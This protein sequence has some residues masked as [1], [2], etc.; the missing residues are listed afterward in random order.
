MVANR[1]LAE[2]E[3]Q[4]RVTTV[5]GQLGAMAV[6]RQPTNDPGRDSAGKREKRRDP[7][8]GFTWE[9]CWKCE[10]ARA[11]KELAPGLHAI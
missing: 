7:P 1:Y 4:K 9:Q 5:T 10:A 3:R 11:A 8:A 6:H 2:A